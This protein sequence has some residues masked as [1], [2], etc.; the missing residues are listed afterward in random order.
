MNAQNF[1]EAAKERLRPSG[2]AEIIGR[3]TAQHGDEAK[4]VD[5]S[6]RHHSRSAVVKDAE[7]QQDEAVCNR[8]DDADRMHQ[9]V[10]KA[11]A[12]ARI[13]IRR[14]A[15]PEAHHQTPLIAPAIDSALPAG[16]AV[17]MAAIILG[18]VRDLRVQST[19]R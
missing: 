10:R 13:M 14:I 4:G 11:L 15:R 8:G 2:F 12:S 16:S 6:G 7:G 19:E 1:I 17:K 18:D 9:T 3:R 5:T